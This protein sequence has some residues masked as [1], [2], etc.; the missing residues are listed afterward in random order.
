VEPVA[1]LVQVLAV[2]VGEQ[3]SQSQALEIGQHHQ[4][5]GHLDVPH[6]GVRLMQMGAEP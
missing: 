1:A 6:L 2:P 4:P 3:R 5:V